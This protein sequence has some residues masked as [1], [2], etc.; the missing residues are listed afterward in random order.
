MGAL[1]LAHPARY[2]GLPNVVL[3]AMSVGVPVV[4]TDTQQGILDFVSHE[5]TGLVVPSESES[6]LA[7]AMR[8]LIDD[9]PLRAFLGRAGREAIQPCLPEQAM[10][11]W[12]NVIAKT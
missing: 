9:E 11:I 5:K 4:V 12:D 3:E 1:F 7:T 2:E 10:K 6:S 8:R